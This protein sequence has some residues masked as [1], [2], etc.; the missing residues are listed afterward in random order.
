MEFREHLMEGLGSGYQTLWKHLIDNVLAKSPVRFEL[1]LIE[2]LV[3]S[4]FVRKLR[5]VGGIFQYID[6]FIA[7]EGRFQVDQYSVGRALVHP[8][9]VDG[10]NS[11][12][13]GAPPVLSDG[14]QPIQ[15]DSDIDSKIDPDLPD[16][17]AQILELY[18]LVAA[19]VTDENEMTP[20][21]HHLV[22]S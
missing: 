15:C 19:G 3:R 2:K 16:G 13:A 14:S 20:A 1:R 11:V 5:V 22:K 7:S 6:R 8:T 12:V 10:S 4:R 21:Q 9:I 17:I 18:F